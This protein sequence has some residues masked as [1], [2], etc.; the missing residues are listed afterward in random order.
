MLK[1][2]LSLFRSNDAIAQMGDDFQQMLAAARELTIRAGRIFWDEAGEADEPT[3]ISK[4]DVAINKLERSI[5]RQV[6]THLTLG[7]ARRDVTYSLLLMSIVKDVER[8][9]D[10]AKNLAEVR[11]EGG[12][13]IPSDANGDELRKLRSIVENAFERTSDV[14]RL[15]DAGGATEL[16]TELRSVN[17]RCDQLIA[18]VAKGSYDAATTTSLVL[19]ARYYKRI[20]SHILNVLSGV[21]MPLH[22]L[23]YYDEDQLDL[24]DGSEEE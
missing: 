14:F 7:S 8:I 19:G 9:G 17:R 1:E 4:A 24:D 11:G 3:A 18:S 5:R 16:M 23:D 10:Y 13:S 20:G 22:K 12:A 2:L 6:I 21:V 15:S